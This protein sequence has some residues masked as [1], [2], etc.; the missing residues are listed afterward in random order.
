MGLKRTNVGLGP[1]PPTARKKLP[2]KT[3]SSFLWFCQFPVWRST[4]RLMKDRHRRND[5]KDAILICG[6]RGEKR[7][8]IRNTPELTWE[9]SLLEAT[10]RA[11]N[12]PC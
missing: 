2:W 12:A 8:A 5:C 10:Q 3:G 6:R 1:N 7:V 11:T 9:R 4:R